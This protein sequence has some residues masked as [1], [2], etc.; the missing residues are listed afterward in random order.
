MDVY[1]I[2]AKLDPITCKISNLDVFV[3]FTQSFEF[4]TSLFKNKTESSL[5]LKNSS[6]KL[7]NEYVWTFMSFTFLD[8]LI[9]VFCPNACESLGMRRILISANR[10]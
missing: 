6:K 3:V 8:V 1:A 4:V 7:E 2:G 9:C 10:I 5:P